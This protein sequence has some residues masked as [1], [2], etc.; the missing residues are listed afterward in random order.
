MGN[1]GL[2]QHP[3]LLEVASDRIEYRAASGP[4]WALGVSEIAAVGEYTTTAGPAD[5]YFLVFVAHDG[6]WREA[7]FYA[8]GVETA[9]QRLGALLGAPLQSGLANSTSWQTRLLWPGQA[10]D[11]PLFELLPIVPRGPVQR[12]TNALAGGPHSVVLSAE[13][14]RLLPRSV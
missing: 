13:A 6:T 9:L 14:R 4:F 8:R 10:S 3:H 12:I 1:R 7:S 2:A 5:D 11:Q